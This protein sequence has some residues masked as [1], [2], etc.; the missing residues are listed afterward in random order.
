MVE[1]PYSLFV[2]MDII[3]KLRLAGI[4]VKGALVFGGVEKGTLF[5][6]QDLNGN[7]IYEWYD[8]V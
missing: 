2:P 3:S 6:H 7:L 8:D 1:A 4:P 5:E